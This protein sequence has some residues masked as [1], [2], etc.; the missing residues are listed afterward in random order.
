M[1]KICFLN[2]GREGKKKK[3]KPMA[4]RPTLIMEILWG[5][6]KQKCILFGFFFDEFLS[7]IS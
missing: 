4:S 2:K 5:T 3:K 7:L 1:H 6:P